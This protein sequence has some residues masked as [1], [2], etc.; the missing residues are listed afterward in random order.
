MV[1]AYEALYRSVLAERPA[2][3]QTSAE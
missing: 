1:A 3:V 2:R